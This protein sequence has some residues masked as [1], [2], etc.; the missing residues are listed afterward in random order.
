MYVDNFQHDSDAVQYRDSSEGTQLQGLAGAGCG[1]LIFSSPLSLDAYN[2]WLQLRHGDNAGWQGNTPNTAIR[3]ADKNL[4]GQIVPQGY[5]TCSADPNDDNV[6]LWLN[7]ESVPAAFLTG[8]TGSMR[9]ALI[10]RDNPL[11][12]TPA[13]T[14]PADAGY[15]MSLRPTFDWNDVTDAGS[16]FVQVSKNAAFTQIVASGNAINSTYV[17]VRDLPK[18]ITLYWRVKANGAADSSDW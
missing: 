15:A 13:L 9:Y 3:L 8:Q 4:A 2:P 16:Y 7:D 10:A 1:A 11:L 18:N 17:P 12:L 14:L 5:I 6:G